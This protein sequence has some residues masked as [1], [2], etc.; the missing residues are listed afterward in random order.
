E[1][2]PL[3]LLSG[4]ELRDQ[5]SRGRAEIQDRLGSAVEFLSVPFGFL[6]SRVLDAALDLGFTAVCDSVSWPAR[7]G[8]HVIHRIAINRDTSE[9]EFESLVFRSAAPFLARSLHRTVLHIPKQILL[10]V[11]PQ[12]LGLPT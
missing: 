6:N 9:R 5:L 7:I 12:L 1:H 3:T 4:P 2:I 8:S 10:R 11:A